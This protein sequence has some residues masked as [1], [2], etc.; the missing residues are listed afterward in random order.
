MAAAR[1]AKWWTVAK[2][3]WRAAF[4][5]P[6]LFVLLGLWMLVAGDFY[7][8]ILV[9]TQDTDI[10]PL[11]QNLLILVL[12]LAPLLSMR[13]LAEERRAGTEE[14]MLTAPLSPAQWVGGKYVG[15]LCVW[16]VF[17][18]AAF[19]FPLVNGRLAQVDWGVVGAS[20][21]GLWLFGAACLAVGLF[22]SA[23]TDNTLFAAMIGFVIVMLLYAAS[24]FGSAASG[25]LGTLLQYI[26][27]PGEYTNFGLGLIGVSQLVYF[28]SL[29]A[30][31]LFLA[32][33]AVDMRR[34]T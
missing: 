21:L 11:I 8:A 27:L 4:A 20:Y 3:E 12:F 33:R 26:S 6:L 14:L 32:V 28:I 29:A 5:S 30:G 10:G 18:A 9:A 24:F 31:F 7:V 16:T 25:W 2:R 23:L 34:W 19:L 1:N 22:A 17:V 13:L 15:V